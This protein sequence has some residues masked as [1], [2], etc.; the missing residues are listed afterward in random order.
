MTYF[1]GSARPSRCR[2]ARPSGLP[3]RAPPVDRDRDR[4]PARCRLPGLALLDNGDVEEDLGRPVRPGE[5]DDRL[6]PLPAVARGGRHHRRDRLPVRARA[7]RRL[8]RPEG[9]RRLRRATCWPACSLQA[10]LLSLLSALLAVGIEKAIA[11]AV[12]MSVEVP[13]VTLRDAA[14]GRGRW[15][16]AGGERGSR[17]GERLRSTRRLPSE[18]RDDRS[19]AATS[20]SSTQAAATSCGRSTASASRFRAASSRCCW[21]PADAERR[22]SCRCWRRSSVPRAGASRLDGLEVTRPQRAT[23]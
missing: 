2:C 17:S 3:G 6:H 14:A 13:T 23:R 7:V 11:P 15:S 5:A 20:R 8:R 21:A 18:R 19:N 9:D 1:A 12:A 22:P 10:V 16:G 4:G